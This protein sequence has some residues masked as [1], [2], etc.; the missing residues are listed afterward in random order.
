MNPCAAGPVVDPRAPVRLL[1]LPGLDGTEAFFGPLLERLPP[2]ILPQVLCY[3]ASG[4]NGYEDLYPL[5]ELA[6]AGPGPCVVLGWSFGGPLALMLAHRQ[7]SRVAGLILCS[8]FVLPPIPR[9][10]PFR[11]ALVA[12]VVAAIRALRRTRMLNPGIGDPAL[13]RAK[14]LTWRRVS[15]RTLA[16][17]AR[18]ALAVDARSALAG[19]VQPL[20]YLRAV[21]DEIIPRRS[22]EVIRAVAPHTRVAELEAP[23]LAL[24]THPAQSV[25]W[26]ADFIERDVLR[27]TEPER[28]PAAD[29]TP[30][31]APCHSCSSAAHPRTHS[32]SV[33]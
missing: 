22:L 24:F 6:L 15:S 20:L 14:A 30:S 18:A 28:P 10:A 17:R 27:K 26:I 23:H 1:L 3:P 8:S 25:A 21:Q 32:P 31:S 5:A 13:R 29:A 12:P 2:W 11:F 33:A 16:A 4:P 7:P 19:C 9:L